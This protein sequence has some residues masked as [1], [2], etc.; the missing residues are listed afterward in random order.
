MAVEKH[1]HLAAFPLNLI[2]RSFEQV[3][4]IGRSLTGVFFDHSSDDA[5]TTEKKNGKDQRRKHHAAR[6]RRACR[7]LRS[8]SRAVYSS[9]V[10]RT[11][12]LSEN[13]A[14]TRS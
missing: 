10:F 12:D 6:T 8:S 13:C 7:H 2:V 3:P 14:A 9:S 4:D 1:H 11:V 5:A